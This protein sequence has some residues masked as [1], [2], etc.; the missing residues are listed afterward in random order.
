MRL[1]RS[2]LGKGVLLLAAI[3]TLSLGFETYIRLTTD[4]VHSPKWNFHETVG[5]GYV[6]QTVPPTVNSFGCIDK[7][8]AIAKP[9]GLTRVLLLGDSFVSGRLI[10]GFLE[11]ALH[12]QRPQERFEVIPMGF[13]GMGLPG[14]MAYFKTFGQALAPDIVVVVINHATIQNTNA[15]IQAVVFGFQPAT[16]TMPF[17]EKLD[18]PQP[19]YRIIPPCPG[20]KTTPLLSLPQTI[21]VSMFRRLDKGL[22]A[23]LGGSYLYGWF[24]EAVLQSDKELQLRGNDAQAAYRLAQLRQNPTYRRDLDGWGYPNDLDMADMFLLPESELPKAFRDSMDTTTFLLADL[25]RQCRAAGVRLVAMLTPDCWFLPDWRL[26]RIE[27]RNAATKR[28]VNPHGYADK[29]AAIIAAAEVEAIDVS[30]AFTAIG[31]ARA[32]KANDTHFN[33]TGEHLAAEATARYLLK[34]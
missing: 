16:P 5:L 33:E 20:E 14:Q 18:G 28:V 22:N 19:A 1:M 32:Y 6:P 3:I 30:P 21:E 17:C 12:K 25:N 26:K 11:E 10:T 23:L 24:R 4:Y 7:E 31:P 29:I 34:P 15:V 13:P 8:R 9:Q 27:A 2:G